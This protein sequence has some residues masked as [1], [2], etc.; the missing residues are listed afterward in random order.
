MYDVINVSCPY[1]KLLCYSLTGYYNEAG[2]ALDWLHGKTREKGG[3]IFFVFIT[4]D[5]EVQNDEDIHP[6]TDI[7]YMR[8]LYADSKQQRLPDSNK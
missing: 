1:N 2:R 4:S 5:E 3:S 6:R 7:E 8:Q